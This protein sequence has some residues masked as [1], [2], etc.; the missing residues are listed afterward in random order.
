MAR[1]SGKNLDIHWAY[2]SGTTA[3][4]A[5][6]RSLSITEDQESADST[7][8]DDTYKTFIAT[9][10]D[11]KAEV[12]LVQQD[13]T[14]GTTTWGVLAPNTEGTLHWFPSGSAAGSIWY[15]MPA[16]VS[17]RNQEFPYDDVVSLTVGFQCTGS[18]TVGTA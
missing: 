9:F 5:D 17:S 7:A 8:G 14:S 11:A 2:S 18:A 1:Y 6:F 12:Q 10:A 16:F 4:E 13:G 15:Y 3:L